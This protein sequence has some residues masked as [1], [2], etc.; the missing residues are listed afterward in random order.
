MIKV[1]CPNCGV[2]LNAPDELAGK[3]VNC[4]KC[5][6]KFVLSTRWANEPISIGSAKGS[7]RIP[8]TSDTKSTSQSNTS[9]SDSSRPEATP[10]T[11][12]ESSSS[13]ANYEVNSDARPASQLPVPSPIQPSA[14]PVESAYSPVAVP[15]RNPPIDSDAENREIDGPLKPPHHAV[16]NTSLDSSG[17]VDSQLKSIA[18]A[19]TSQRLRRFDIDGFTESDSLLDLFDFRFRR[20]MTPMI[21]KAS[22]IVVLFIAI[23]WG[24]LATFGY[25]SS[26]LNSPS[27][28]FSNPIADS[29]SPQVVKTGLF[30]SFLIGIMM[31]VLW[32]RVIFESIL[33]LFHI[34]NLMRIKKNSSE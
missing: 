11:S 14:I 21:L 17:A 19:N 6:S 3:P 16:A 10:I 1:N 9:R 15:A 5:Q 33:M 31:A 26:I 13:A 8:Q 27:V 2:R 18:Q 30:L 4:Q 12:H 29:L 28:E 25:A 22:W 20:Y 7:Q 24:L 34:G 23:G 32:I